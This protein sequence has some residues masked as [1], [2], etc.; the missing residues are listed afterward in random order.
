MPGLL[1]TVGDV[2]TKFKITLHNAK[3]TTIG[4]RVEDFFIITDKDENSLDQEQQ[5]TLQQALIV[6][7]EKLNR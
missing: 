1:A 5:H 6:A 2:F 3:I 4:E 7:I